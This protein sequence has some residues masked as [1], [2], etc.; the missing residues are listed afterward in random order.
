LAVDA[1][2]SLL[3]LLPAAVV[4]GQRVVKLVSRSLTTVLLM[5][6]LLAAA[7][8]NLTLSLGSRRE[9]CWKGNTGLNS[10][11]AVYRCFYV[12]SASVDSNLLLAPE[13]RLVLEGQHWIK[14]AS[15]SFITV[16]MLLHF[17][18]LQSAWFS[19]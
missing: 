17:C 11:R 10:P 19:N 4:L 12:A 8:A 2:I 9:C 14:L 7:W 6:L 15:R 5:L 18:L 1:A 13:V 16:F 3:L